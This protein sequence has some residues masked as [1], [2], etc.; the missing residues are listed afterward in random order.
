MRLY[1]EDPADFLPRAGTVL[2]W[3][4]PGGPGVRVDSGVAAGFDVSVEY[5]PL[6]AKIIAHAEDR[7]AAIE[8]AL[9]ALDELVVLGVETNRSLLAAVLLSKE[10]RS[11]A[12]ATDLVSRLP[13]VE[14]SPAPPAA[15]I[16]AA[17]AL[18]GNAPSGAPSASARDPWESGDR[19]RPGENAG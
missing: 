17:L 16:A 2:E 14:P 7:P 13:R 5:D 19:W 10:F 9:R 11:G 15:W 12:Y 8:R 1:A 18:S 3:V 4:E 6:L